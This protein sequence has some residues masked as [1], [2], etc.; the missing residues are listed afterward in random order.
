MKSTKTKRTLAA[1]PM[2]P[3][4][5]KAA[6]KPLPFEWPRDASIFDRYFAIDQQQQIVRL[7]HAREAEGGP[8]EAEGGPDK[9]I[10]TLAEAALY[11]FGLDPIAE[12]A[13]Y[14]ISEVVLGTYN[15]DGHDLSPTAKILEGTDESRALGAAWTLRQRAA[16]L[17][18]TP[19]E[20]K[21]QE[22]T[23]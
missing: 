22:A 9:T 7:M 4:K 10:A 16:E 21:A 20:K 6:R 18:E 11:L 2:N 19:R 3:A 14:R 5:T 13:F 17:G 23:S 1:V 12:E 8:S 15:N